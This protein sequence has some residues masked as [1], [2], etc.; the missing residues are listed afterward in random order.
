MKFCCA[1]PKVFPAISKVLL[2]GVPHV[3]LATGTWTV[4]ALGMLLQ[5]KASADTL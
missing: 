2:F 5:G 1:M 4:R 3:R